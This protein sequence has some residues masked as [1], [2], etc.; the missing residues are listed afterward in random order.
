LGRSSARGRVGAASAALAQPPAGSQVARAEAELRINPDLAVALLETFLR[1]ESAKAGFECAVV[2]LSGGIDSALAAALSARAFGASHVHLVYL[3]YRTSNPL[4]AVHARAVARLLGRP[5]ERLPISAAV[6]GFLR[7]PAFHEADPRR[8][9]N[10][11]A[12]MR[13]IA[14]YDVSARLRG[15]VIGTSN[16]TELL[17]GYGTQW[18]DLASA[19]N[20]LGD[21][22]KTQVRQLAAHLR[23]P[24][25]V[26]RKEPSADLWLGQTDEAD[27]GLDYPTADRVLWRLVD[28]RMPPGSV[29]AEGFDAEQVRSVLALMRRN[30]F[31][32]RPPLIGTLGPRT[33][34]VDFRYPRDWGI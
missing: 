34:G 30:Q 4:S 5:L 11:M 16:K 25:A 23:L 7:Q 33:V 9:G 20:P 10:V 21:L 31:K 24:R 3:P 15:L 29:V 28:R 8:R 27:L 26:L 14:L 32:R 13:M 2:G 1:D 17:L 19:L 12:R 18:G 6:D 22:Y